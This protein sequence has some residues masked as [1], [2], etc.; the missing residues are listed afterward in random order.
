MSILSWLKVAA[1]TIFGAALVAV[2]VLLSRNQKLKEEVEKKEIQIKLK[3][4]QQKVKDKVA[5]NEDELIN[6]NKG[7]HSES[8]ADRINRVLNDRDS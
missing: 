3:V 6:E 1:L 2:K 8:R 7:D 5:K 4:D